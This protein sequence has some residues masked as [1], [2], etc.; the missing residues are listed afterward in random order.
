MPRTPRE[1]KQELLIDIIQGLRSVV[2]KFDKGDA[3]AD[4]AEKMRRENVRVITEA[5][6]KH[7]LHIPPKD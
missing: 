3:A 6:Q 1:A 5:A 2:V 7:G 4:V